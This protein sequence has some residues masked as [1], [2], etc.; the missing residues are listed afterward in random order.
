MSR[1]SFKEKTRFVKKHEREI[2]PLSE[3]KNLSTLG[4]RE[5]ENVLEIFETKLFFHE[6]KTDGSH[7]LLT[8]DNPGSYSAIQPLLRELEDDPSCGALSIIISG[9]AE[10]KFL[11]DFGYL[12]KGIRKEHHL[13]G[14]LLTQASQ[15]PIDIILASVSSENGPESIALFGGKSSLGS[16]KIFFIS[17]GWSGLGSAFMVNSERM[18]DINGIF[19]NDE[20]AKKIILYQIPNFPKEKILVT[21]T[22]VLD[23]LEFSRAEEYRAETRENLQI[24]KDTFTFLY[25][26]DV[27]GSYEEIGVQSDFNE[28]T[29]LFSLESLRTVARKR[30]DKKL[31]FVFRPHPRDPRKENFYRLVKDFQLPDNMSIHEGGSAFSINQVSYGADVISSI[32][33]TENHFA[34]LRGPKAIFLGYEEMG[35]KILESVYGDKILE[36]IRQTQNISVVSN[37]EEL[38]DTLM[39]LIDEN[40]TE[41]SNNPKVPTKG[42]VTEKVLNVIFNR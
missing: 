19:C 25:L 28:K 32:V 10:K 3:E 36:E 42:S 12:Y 30:K 38:E 11:H 41:I 35:E 21:G 40:F 24:T 7:I 37:S 26:G 18:D 33:S 39:G 1:E 5:L 16:Q 4:P 29:F 14:D 17:E 2:L 31:A 23:T 34:S 13:I 22:P 15:K 8:S 6:K 9:I 27:S 20:L